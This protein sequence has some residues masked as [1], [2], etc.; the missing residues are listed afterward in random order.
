MQVMG[1][2]QK[3][4]ER[5]PKLLACEAELLQMFRVL[6]ESFECGGKLL[7]C[8]NGGSAADADHIVGELMKGF[9]LPR[10]V[11][12]AER[13]ALNALAGR[14]A[15]AALQRALPAVCLGAG[16]ALATAVMN[17]NSPAMVFAQQVYGLGKPGD[18]LLGLSTSG[19][20][21]NVIQAFHVAKVRRM[22]C[23]LLTGRTGGK[24]KALADVAVCVP[25]I[26]VPEV[27]ELHL[28]IYHAIC[29]ALEEHFFGEP[30]ACAPGQA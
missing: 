29:A 22:K 2:F 19:N 3:L 15:A 4:F 7:T 17:D 8:G 24:L 6:V 10:P 5:H 27:Q 25:A 14:D 12:E 18:V 20:S 9:L 13:D 1:H 23:L 16:G 11:V 28:P 21:E 26:R 30:S